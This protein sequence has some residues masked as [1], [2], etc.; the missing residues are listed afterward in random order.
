MSGSATFKPNIKWY[1]NKDSVTFE[2]DHRDIK[3]ETIKIEPQQISI[4]FKHENKDYEDVLELFSEID[5]KNSTIAVT[6]YSINVH[7]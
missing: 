6:G 7:L 2:L 4:Q 3:N 5:E 1:Q